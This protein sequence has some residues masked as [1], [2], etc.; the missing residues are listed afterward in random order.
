MRKIKDPEPFWSRFGPEKVPGF[1]QCFWRAVLQQLFR[2][3][4]CFYRQRPRRFLKPSHR[5]TTRSRGRKYPQ[6]RRLLG[7][8]CGAGTGTPARITKEAAAHRFSRKCSSP[9][10]CIKNLHPLA[11]EMV[12]AHKARQ[13]E[14]LAGGC[15]RSMMAAKSYCAAVLFLY[16]PF[17]ICR[18]PRHGR[19]RREQGSLVSGSRAGCRPGG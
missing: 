8:L 9:S 2:M 5:R 10:Y 3:F 18:P 6:G 16:L 19:A 1:V 12:A 17:T 4:G 13:I 14:G 15:A 11:A 7:A